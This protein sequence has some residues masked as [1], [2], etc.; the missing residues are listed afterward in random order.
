MNKIDKYL[1]IVGLSVA[2]FVAVM[3]WL[4]NQYQAVP[5]TLIVA[6]FAI[7]GGECGALAMIKRM[8][9]RKW[10]KEDKKNEDDH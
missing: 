10:E 1:L 3:V 9:E 5:D 2:V 4:F 6:F 7:M 8:K